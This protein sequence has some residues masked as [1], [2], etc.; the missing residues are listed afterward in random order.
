M[1]K[2]RACFN[3]YEKVSVHFG[4]NGEGVQELSST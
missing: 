4:L 3:I 1:F 2:K